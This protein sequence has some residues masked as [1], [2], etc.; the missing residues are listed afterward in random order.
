MAVEETIIE[1]TARLLAD[2]RIT[3]EAKEG[4]SAFIDKRKPSW[5]TSIT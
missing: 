1:K 4:I 5:N 3:A 2:T